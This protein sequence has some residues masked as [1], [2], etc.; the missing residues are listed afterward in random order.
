MFVVNALVGNVSQAFSLVQLSNMWGN[1]RPQSHHPRHLLF[2]RPHK[3][4]R[5]ATEGG[6]SERQPSSRRALVHS[7]FATPSVMQ[8]A[9]HSGANVH[10]SLP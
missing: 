8:M 10:I 1:K 9:V 6:R 5:S 3:E 2:T 7:R 4:R